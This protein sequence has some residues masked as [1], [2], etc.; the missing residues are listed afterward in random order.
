MQSNA[1]LRGGRRKAEAAAWHDACWIA[2]REDTQV[3]QSLL[4]LAAA[5]FWTIANAGSANAQGHQIPVLNSCIREFYDPG[6]YN[7]LTYQNNCTQSVTLVFVT[8]NGSGA[9]GTMDLRPGGRDSV[10]KL[11]GK[12]PKIGDL[13][14]YV[15]PTGHMPVDDSGKTVTK[16]KTEY[17]CQP[18]TK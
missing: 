4:C 13:Q 11:A 6:M 10:G 3:R 12:A 14:L 5:A 1:L 8:K 9:S 7:Y 15:C 18:K 2:A 17:Q 16:P